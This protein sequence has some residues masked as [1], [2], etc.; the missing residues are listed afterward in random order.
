MRDSEGYIWISTQDGLTKYNGTDFIQYNYD[1]KNENSIG[2][3]YVWTTFEDSRNNIWIGLFGGGLCR[4]DKTQ[5]KFY[6]YNDYGTIANHGTRT[7]DQLNDSTLIV[8]TDHGLYLFDLDSF[9]FDTDTTFQKRQFDLGH[10]H[11]HSLEVYDSD[12]LIAGENGGYILSTSDKSVEKI[13]L[14]PLGIEKIGFLKRIDHDKLLLTGDNTFL[15]VTYNKSEKNFKVNRRITSNF[16]VTV[17]DMS[18]DKTGSILLTA[19]EGLFKLNFEDDSIILIPHD[20]PQKNNLIDKVAY[21]V[22]EIEPNLKWIGTKTNIYEFSERKKP[23]DHILSDQL[24][25]SAVLGMS[26]D[27]DGNLWVATRRGLARVKHFDKPQENWEYFCYDE[28]SNPELKNQYILN[29]KIIED[30]ILVGHRRKGFSLLQIKSDDQVS[31]QNPPEN[32]DKLTNDGSVSNFLL[33]ENQ[34]IWISTSGNGVI[35]W[36]YQSPSNVLQF[37]NIDGQTNVLSHNY[38]F[39]FEEIDDSWIAVATAAGISLINKDNDST[40]QILSGKDS[41]SLSG[42]FIMDF[43]R[44]AKNQLWVCTD[45]GINLWQENNTFKNWTKNEGL[46]N[47]IIYGMLESDN[48]LWIST[49][50]GL[51]RFQNTES[52]A[53]K[54]FSKNDDV[55]NEEHNQFSFLKS[56]KNNLLF[57]G[58]MGITFFNPDDIKSNT[59]DARPVIESFQLFNKNG[60]SRLKSHINY[61]DELILNHN[62]NFLSFDLA[63]LSYY[64]PD[65]NRYRY[66]LSPLN[67]NWIEM[68]ER[69]FFSLNGLAPGQYNLA[70]QSSNNDGKWGTPIKKIDIKI[71]RPIYSRWYAWL[72]YALVFFSIVYAFYR[73]KINHITNLS[74]VREDERTKIRE[75]SARDFH[76]EVG[77]YITKLSLLN[78][79]LLSEM[80]TESKDN[81]GILNKMQSN[82]QRIRTGMKDFI[83][84]LDPSKDLLESTII[85]IKEIGN[86]L[87]EHTGI[88]FQCAVDSSIQ[89]NMELNGVQRRQLILL[90]KESLHNVVKHAK[91]KK[92]N[93]KIS[94]SDQ[95]LHFTVIDDGL[96]FDL[97]SYEAGYGLKSLH[98]RAR[99]MNGTVEVKSEIS[100]GT[101]INVVIPTHPNGL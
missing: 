20:Q 55:L 59:I 77:S 38:T 6:R 28:N 23:F 71:N 58:K 43:H 94:Q 35:K 83:W 40:D 31:F 54:V 66:R 73:M 88:K 7:L 30:L 53:F 96:G 89:K 98:E 48:E 4:F 67:E 10:I 50:K 39:G 80:P 65:Q 2:H 19:E 84:V 79:Y 49:N 68:G 90:I 37:K 85:K 29:V 26:E 60:N 97:N 87:F 72:F 8:G 92:C 99:K 86:D 32:V 81:I 82:I 93:I 100:Q 74:S 46:P 41:F 75:R 21:C 91:A 69:N 15:E 62:E 52:P 22:E 5:D 45:G 3:N 63:S 18:L 14:D 1:R 17:N 44:D 13:N 47:D 101:Q 25:G 36:N 34:N 16:K 70:I 33:D 56:K 51:V 57:G 24:C 12:I 95:A 27:N 76:D 61:T 9:S 42:N 11:T 78:Q 64:K